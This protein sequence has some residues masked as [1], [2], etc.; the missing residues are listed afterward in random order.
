MVNVT[1]FEVYGCWT[2]PE[3]KVECECGTVMEQVPEEGH[4]NSKYW[5][6]KRNDG[7]VLKCCPKG[8]A[9]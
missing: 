2:S 6:L 4:F 5:A 9:V 7:M 3:S 1:D 8:C